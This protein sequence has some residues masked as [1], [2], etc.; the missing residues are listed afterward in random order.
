MNARLQK[1]SDLALQCDSLCENLP[2]AEAEKLRNELATLQVICGTKTVGSHRFIIY[3]FN[4]SLTFSFFMVALLSYFRNLAIDQFAIP[5][6]DCV[7][8]VS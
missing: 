8:C 1:M 2:P 7:F 3:V 6:L 4:H 5:R